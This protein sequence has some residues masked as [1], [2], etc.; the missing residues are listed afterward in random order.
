MAARGGHLGGSHE[1]ARSGRSLRRTGSQEV[2]R[3]H[4]VDDLRPASRSMLIVWMLW[5]YNMAFGN[6]HTSGRPDRSGAGSSVTSSPS[7][8]IGSEQGQAVSGA[9]TSDS[10]PLPDRDPGVLP[11]RLRRD[12]APVVLGRARGS[13]QV[14]GVAADRAAVDHA[15]LL[16]ERRAALGRWLLRPEGC[17][18]LLRWLR[19]SPLGGGGRLRGGV[20]DRTAPL[21]GPRERL[22]HQSHDGGGGGGNPLA[23]LERL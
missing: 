15:G 18:R 5:G 4:D 19:H 7:R 11:V 22:P 8:P 3:Q 21:A 20:D 14:Q 23:W 13:P 12:H 10:V 9:N 6:S 16:R 2:D 1:F 17:G